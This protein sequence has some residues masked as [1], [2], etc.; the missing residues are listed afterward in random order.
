MNRCWLHWLA[1]V[2]VLVWLASPAEHLAAQNTDADKDKIDAAVKKGVEFLKKAPWHFMNQVAPGVKDQNE[3]GVAALCGMALL[4]SDVPRLDPSVQRAINLVKREAPNLSKVYPT[5]LGVMLLN[6][7]GEDPALI[8][9]LTIRLLAAQ[10]ANGAWTYDCPVLTVDQERAW[11]R[12]FRE[13][14]KLDKLEQQST[15]GVANAPAAGLI[16]PDNSNTQFAVLALWLGRKANVPVKYALLRAEHHFR[17]SQQGDGGWDY[18]MG[19]VPRSTA[20]MTCAGLLALAVGHGNTQERKATFMA[21]SDAKDDKPKKDGPQAGSGE[22]N[23]L[24]L[25]QLRED[26]QVLK[27]RG[28]VE[29]CIRNNTI[30][31]FLY[32]LWSLERVCVVYDWHKNN[33]WDWYNWG[34]EVL[35]KSQ[36]Q[37]GG[38]EYEYGRAVDTA[39]AL[40]F[41]RRAN[42]LQ[43]FK[44]ATLRQDS[45]QALKSDPAGS[46]TNAAVKDKP[47]DDL[48]DDAKTLGRELVTSSGTRREQIIAKMRDAK[49]DEFTMALA[50]NIPQLTGDDQKLAR[51]ALGK[52]LEAAKPDELVKYMQ[53]NDKEL[54]LAA[55][56]AASTKKGRDPGKE[57]PLPLIALLDNF[58]DAIQDAAYE[59]LKKL[60][61]QDFGRMSAPWKAWWSKKIGS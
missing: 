50:K 32:F 59:A 3:V 12:F 49:G 61:G 5:A 9:K 54:Q 15:G 14:E 28:F 31:H 27:A 47:K 56:R 60:T 26:D 7:A 44:K 24:T 23:S 41:L 42:L 52:R 25:D 1:S 4:E 38:W 35:L 21:S 16:G 36:K 13:R 43:E 58:E 2:G 40:L 10:H 45:G 22:A 33:W 29:S 11:E 17:S 6:R 30:E 8:R 18:G 48:P 37:D 53:S 39:F 46:K 57:L 20:G 51:E 34:S 19:G 55:A